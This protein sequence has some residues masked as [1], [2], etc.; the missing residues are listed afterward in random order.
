MAG[1]IKRSV[2]HR[3]LKQKG[4]RQEERDHHRFVF[5]YRGKRTAISTF[6]SHGSKSGDID[7]GLLNLMKRELRLQNLADAR[8]LVRCKM[9]EEEYIRLVRGYL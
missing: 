5:Y 9:S 8:A 4:F 6:T 2:A 3:C 7:T 1:T